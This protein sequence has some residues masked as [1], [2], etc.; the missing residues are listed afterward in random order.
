MITAL[1]MGAICAGL[2]SLLDLS[3]EG[4]QELIAPFVV[5]AV[6]IVLWPEMSDS[7]RERWPTL[8]RR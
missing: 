6:L 3:N 5:I 1:L 7:V 2:A 8:R 4:T